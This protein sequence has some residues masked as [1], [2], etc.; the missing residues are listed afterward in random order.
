MKL[1]QRRR[2][3]VLLAALLVSSP[4]VAKA[5][6]EGLDSPSAA[7]VE[8]FSGP[9][10]RPKRHFR[11]SDAAELAPADAEAV[12]TALRQELAERYGRSGEALVS[13]YQLWQRYNTVPYG[14]MTHGRRFVNNYANAAAR[15]YGLYEAAGRLPVGSVLAKDSFVVLED[16]KVEPG[17]LFVME[18]MPRGFNYVTGDWRYSMI[19][20][21][22]ELAGRTKG[23]RAERVEFCISCHL[24]KEDQDHLFFLPRELRVTP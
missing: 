22:G 9:P 12:Y 8:S 18:K 7:P 3:G 2:L 14:S 1:L 6:T 21:Q 11:V 13:D 20:P 4:A 10:E 15:A 23:F 16:G 17:P 5:Q 19:S 24:A